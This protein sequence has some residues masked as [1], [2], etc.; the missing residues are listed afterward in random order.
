MNSLQ[1]NVYKKQ[2]HIFSCNM[3]N[4]FIYII[5]LIYLLFGPA[6]A[7]AHAHTATIS[8]VL[9]HTENIVLKW[10]GNERNNRIVKVIQ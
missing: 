5:F 7:A 8:K 2:A 4:I 10:I 6:A 1:E 9:E 3:I